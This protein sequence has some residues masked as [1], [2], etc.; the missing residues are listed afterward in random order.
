MSKDL[1]LDSLAIKDS[2]GYKNL[3]AVSEYTKETRKLFRE[4][5]TKVS[6]L[7]NKILEQSQTI[8]NQ[9]IQ[10]STLQIKVL[11]GGA[12]TA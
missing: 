12:T 9:K 8:E 1:E 6:N 7:E 5:E 3:I 10:I 4:L 11:G 2:A